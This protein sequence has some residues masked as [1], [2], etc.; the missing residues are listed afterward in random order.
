MNKR[1]AILLGGLG[2]LLIPVAFTYI[3]FGGD[4]GSSESQEELVDPMAEVTNLNM[5]IPP[6][7]RN[8]ANVTLTTW[9]RDIFTT[10]ES[11]E[12]AK[13]REISDMTEF[14]LSGI[15]TSGLVR[16]AIINE[17]VVTEGSRIDRYIVDSI[18]E[19]KV[20]L[21]WNRKK[22]VLSIN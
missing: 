16:S 12:L 11:I 22:V 2:L 10:A 18:R 3:D 20:V 1:E 4:V 17:Q 6:G 15:M 9:G 7:A 14:T 8:I 19:S 5:L 13:A 21:R